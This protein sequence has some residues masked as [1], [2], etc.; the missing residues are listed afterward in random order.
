MGGFNVESAR[1]IYLIPE[2]I[3][4]IAA[5]AVGCYGDINQLDPQFKEAEHPSPRLSI[6]E[7][8]YKY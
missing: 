2:D 6:G 1:K 4:I 3:T 7:I 8:L 5:V